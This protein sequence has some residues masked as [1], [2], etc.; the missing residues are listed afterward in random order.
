MLCSYLLLGLFAHILPPRCPKLANLH[1]SQLKHHFRREASVTPSLNK[2]FFLCAFRASCV[3]LWKIL[4]Y[5]VV[6]VCLCKSPT[7]LLDAPR[8]ER[9]HPPSPQLC[10]LA[11]CLITQATVESA[12]WTMWGHARRGACL[13][14]IDH[15]LNE[16]LTILMNASVMEARLKE[17]SDFRARPSGLQKRCCAQ[18]GEPWL[19]RLLLPV[20]CDRLCVQEKSSTLPLMLYTKSHLYCS[21]VEK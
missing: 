20:C 4:P 9:I 17:A 19:Q 10:H 13:L 16:V 2:L 3:P 6:S 5:C 12:E 14:G 11:R 8:R 18:W 21:D 7:R 15:C 1:S